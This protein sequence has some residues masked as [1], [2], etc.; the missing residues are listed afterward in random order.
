MGYDVKIPYIKG[1]LFKSNMGY[2]PVA[3]FEV[4]P[5]CP[6]PGELASYRAKNSF[7]PDGYI[8]SYEWDWDNDGIY[9][10]NHTIPTAVHAYNSSQK[11]NVTLRV[12]DNE[13]LNGIKTN[14]VIIDNFPEKPSIYGPSVGNTGGVYN[15][16][17]YA[18]DPD[19]DDIYYRYWIWLNDWHYS[20]GEIGPFSSGTN[21]TLAYTFWPSGDYSVSAQTVDIYGKESEW[22]EVYITIPRTRT[23]YNLNWYNFLNNHIV[24]R[25]FVLRITNS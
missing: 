6:S 22:S 9:D 1:R 8:V 15:F 14:T 16:T 25:W 18:C 7:D 24:L 19:D 2:P 21:G 3:K 10:E 20:Y 23:V 4:N 13:G 17:F 11:Y 12:T 5:P